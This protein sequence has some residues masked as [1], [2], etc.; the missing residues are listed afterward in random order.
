MIIEDFFP[1]IL[2]LAGVSD[3]HQIGGVVDG[4]SFV[5]LLRNEADDSR[6]IR[7]LFWH[8]PNH[9]G[10]KGPGIGPSSSVRRGAWKLIYY[11]DDRRFELFNVAKDIGEKFNLA[12]DYPDMRNK[13]AA[14]LS[15]YLHNVGA[16]FPID[17]KSGKPVMIP[18]Q[19]P[20][21]NK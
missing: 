7:P 14:E 8:F 5:P 21:Q 13:L 17:K 6:E 11:Y 9:W 18:V 16:Q 1:T 20:D 15:M 19:L 4:M 3:I 10:P 2:E 12:N